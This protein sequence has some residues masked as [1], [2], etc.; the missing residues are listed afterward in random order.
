MRYFT[1][2]LLLFGCTFSACNSNTTSTVNLN[3][4][5]SGPTYLKVKGDFC[6]I[7]VAVVGG[8]EITLDGTLEQL[9]NSKGYQLKYLVVEETLK[10]WVDK[11]L[12][13]LGNARGSINLKVPANTRVKLESETGDIYVDGLSGEKVKVRTNSG[14]VF[15]N[16][17]QTFISVKSASGDI[18][19]SGQ[20]GETKVKTGSGDLQLREIKGSLK[21]ITTSGDI[22]LDNFTGSIRMEAGSGEIKG[23]QL[24]FDGHSN[25]ESYSGDIKFRLKAEP[26]SLH[27][28][29][30]S[31]SGNITV[32]DSLVRNRFDN[33]SGDWQ[34]QAHS[35]MGD[36]N[37][38]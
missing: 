30:T 14:D 26:S 25:V 2:L 32:G 4:K 28:L 19:V 27:L 21:A 15:L 11:P 3:Q 12:A 33:G 18:E 34:L 9:S 6:E 7:S 36:I 31:K 16:D 10:V 5:F 37:L 29:L 20:E 23:K 8:T 22:N 38:R 17:L 13:T 35:N 1:F 24:D